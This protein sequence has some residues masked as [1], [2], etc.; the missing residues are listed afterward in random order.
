ML[1]QPLP[2]ECFMSP[3]EK[4]VHRYI[5]T[6]NN[7]EA[8]HRRAGIDE[9]F[10]D[11]CSYIDPIAAVQGRA[12][13]DALI[14]GVQKQFPGAVFHLAGAV[15]VHH[16]Q[17]RFTWHAGAPGASE[18]LVIGFDVVVFEGTRIRSVYGF[19]DKVPS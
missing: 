8:H 1:K 10:T 3:L 6:W 12:G 5:G 9:L 15:D 14:A 2:T 7:V 19:L 11:D 4:A 17:A 16:E 13:V 18:P